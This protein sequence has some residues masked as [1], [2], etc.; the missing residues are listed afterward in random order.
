MWTILLLLLCC[1][2]SLA[3][4]GGIGWKV[5]KTVR[6]RRHAAELAAVPIAHHVTERTAAVRVG[7]FHACELEACGLTMPHPCHDMGCWRRA[8]GSC[9]PI[10][11]IRG[12]A[13]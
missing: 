7:G 9:Q 4:V 10:H 8:A 11:S 3:A 6:A 5:A 1:P 2:G 12:G 13:R